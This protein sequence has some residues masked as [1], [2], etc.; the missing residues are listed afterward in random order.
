M[1][2]REWCY[3]SSHDGWL[4]CSEFG[5]VKKYTTGYNYRCKECALSKIPS[6]YNPRKTQ[7]FN[8]ENSVREILKI[9]G[10]NPDSQ[11]PVH[12]QFLIK[13]DL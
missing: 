2:G 13:H 1:D 7:T 12:E 4:P 6:K 9:I 3:C 8:E 11:I 5:K 10:Y